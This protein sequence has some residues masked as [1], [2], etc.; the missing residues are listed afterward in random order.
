MARK[1]KRGSFRA[2]VGG[3][4]PSGV[5][6]TAGANLNAFGSKYS[7]GRKIP[8]G[9][10]LSNSA[11]KP[12]RPNLSNVYGIKAASRG[13]DLVARAQSIFGT[14]RTGGK[15]RGGGSDGPC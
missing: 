10:G 9:G 6:H 12:A 14:V 4:S 7:V 13:G 8:V 3:Q 11:V 5:G 2:A 1:G 15:V